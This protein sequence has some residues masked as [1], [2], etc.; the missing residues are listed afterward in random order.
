MKLDIA[1]GGN[2]QEGFTGID[3]RK[4][5]GVDIFHNLEV[6]PWPIRKESVQ[7]A[8]ASH[9]IEHI[10]PWLSIDFM[11]EVWRVLVPGGTFC[12]STPYPGSRGYWQDPTHCNGWS[13]VTFQP[14][15]WKIHTGFPTWQ[16]VGNLEVIMEKILVVKGEGK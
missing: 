7:I 12:A 8:I 11:N 9:Y 5:P 15:P 1:C 3:I 14:K 10:K 6:F 4:L 13:E 2:K 16:V